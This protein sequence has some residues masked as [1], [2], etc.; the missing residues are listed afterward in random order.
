MSLDQKH[1]IV[2]YDM[3][4]VKTSFLAAML[5]LCGLGVLTSCSSNE[6]NNIVTPLSEQIAGRWVTVEYEGQSA[7]TDQRVVFNFVSSDK[8]LITML[9]GDDEELGGWINEAPFDVTINGQVVTV[10]GQVTETISSIYELQ[11]SSIK[12]DDMLCNLKM[13]DINNGEVSVGECSAHFARTV[14]DHSA[15]IIGTW[16][17]DYPWEGEKT[18]CHFEFK[19]DGTYNFYYLD[20]DDGKWKQSADD[21]SFY[22]CLGDMIYMRWKNTGM[23]ADSEG[24]DITDIGSGMMKW[25]ALRMGEDDST[26]EATIDF[27]KVQE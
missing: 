12:G 13:T 2:I 15:E 19:E 1:L 6:D 23:D 8:C 10:S 20:D 9:L 14:A 27:K 18:R 22:S 3:E 16:E 17:G 21:Y 25:H 24:W 4:K 5:S 7:I 11:I 26:Y